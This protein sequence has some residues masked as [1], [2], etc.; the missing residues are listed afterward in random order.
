MHVVQPIGIELAGNDAAEY[1]C[2]R[3]K[4]DQFGDIFFDAFFF[5]NPAYFSIG[6]QCFRHIFMM[7]HGQIQ[8]FA[9]IFKGMAEGA[10]PHVMHQS[11]GQRI[12][13]PGR[14]F[15]GWPKA[16][17]YP[18]QLPGDVK[19]A[20]T[21]G[22]TAV[23]RAGVHKIGESQLLYTPQTLKGRCLD[24]FPQHLLKVVFVKL[25]QVMKR[26]TDT[27]RFPHSRYIFIH[28]LLLKRTHLIRATA[29]GGEKNSYAPGRQNMSGLYWKVFQKPDHRYPL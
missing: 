17:Q 2:R 27:L 12:F 1:F 7:S 23:G 16:A 11:G 9:H 26:I 3:W 8:T 21:V 14:R 25:Y 4:A 6:D 20:Q 29:S 5:Q 18:Q 24:H 22:E 13:P 28:Y 15:A 19:S 10:V